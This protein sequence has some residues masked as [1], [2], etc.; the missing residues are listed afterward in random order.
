MGS[1]VAVHRFFSSCCFTISLYFAKNHFK[2]QSV[3]PAPLWGCWPPLSQLRE[4]NTKCVSWKLPA[5]RNTLRPLCS[6]SCYF[7]VAFQPS[8]PGLPAVNIAPL[9]AGAPDLPARLLGYHQQ[10]DPPGTL[11]LLPVPVH[12]PFLCSIFPAPV[13]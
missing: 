9:K 13:A 11:R 6:L 7:C 12:S 2:D 1:F 10:L 8:M 3:Y 5:T 4:H